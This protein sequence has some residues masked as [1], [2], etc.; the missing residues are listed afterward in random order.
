MR[1]LAFLA[2]I[3][4]GLSLGG[5]GAMRTL[6]QDVKSLFG[7]A[8]GEPALAV[9]IRQYEDGKYPEAAE[10]L[11]TALYQGLSSADRVNAHKYL[12]FVHCISSR[13]SAC[14]EQFRRAL[15]L[16]PNLE[17]SAA[18]AGHP[19]WGPVFRAVKAGR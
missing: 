1:A 12:A 10:S 6:Q 9:G 18:E 8:K 15:A 16:D 4:A 3:I 2:L 5:C 17:L 7:S 14:R 13:P 11:N 19:I